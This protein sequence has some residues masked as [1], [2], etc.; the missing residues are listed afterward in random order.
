MKARLVGFA[1]ALVVGLVVAVAWPGWVLLGL[2]IIAWGVLAAFVWR[3][4][5]RDV[6]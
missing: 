2:A 5:Y 6:H 3:D 4:W 1:V